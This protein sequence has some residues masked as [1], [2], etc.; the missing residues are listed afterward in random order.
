MAFTNGKSLKNVFFKKKKGFLFMLDIYLYIIYIYIVGDFMRRAAFFIF[1]VLLFACDNGAG[2]SGADSSSGLGNNPSSSSNGG[3]LEKGQYAVLPANPNSG[4]V[5]E[6]YNRWIDTYYITFEADGA[7]PA[8]SPAGAIGSARIKAVYDGHSGGTHTCSEAIGYGMLAT[9]LMEDWGRFDKLLAYSKAFRVRNKGALMQWSVDGFSVGSGGSATDADIDILASLLIAFEKTNNQS[10]LNDAIEIGAS[11]YEWEVD[12]T[13][14]LILPAVYNDPLMTKKGVF[15][16]IS[17]FSLA[18]IKTLAKYD[19]SRDWNAVLEANLSYME[20][21]QNG[22][23]GL[24]PDWSDANGSPIDPENSSAQNLTPSDGSANI[25][26]YAAYYKEAV[27]IPWRIAWYYHWY[28]DARAKEMLNKGIGFLRSK[29]VN[30]CNV[31]TCDLKDFYSYMGGKQSS[32]DAA[33]PRWVSLCALGMGN[34][35]NQEWLNGCNDKI[36]NFYNFA[37]N[38]YY[39]SSLQLIYAML[40]NGRF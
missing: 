9:S 30:T 19:N 25:R 35:D 14:K 28:G 20:R 34:S 5:Q 3:E 8:F 37:L 10:Y 38:S 21:V 18:A 6:M 2:N 36:L 40:F 27:R 4:K 22:G 29:G 32:S 13:S 24:W 15:Y 1:I 17:Y 11:I 12:A 23:D 39:S 7:D 16:N 31:S 33:I 26:S